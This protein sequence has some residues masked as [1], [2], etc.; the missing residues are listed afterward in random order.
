M[1]RL[2]SHRG[3]MDP[4]ALA[5]PHPKPKV[6]STFM[7]HLKPTFGRKPKLSEQS[8]F[9]EPTKKQNK[10]NI[11]GSETHMY[12]YHA[13]A[14]LYVCIYC[15]HTSA[16]M[17]HW[18]TTELLMH[19]N[20]RHCCHLQN[21]HWLWNQQHMYLYIY[22]AVFVCVCMRLFI[23]CTVTCCLNEFKFCHTLQHTHRD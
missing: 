11:F 20:H 7:A 22:N 13:Y 8:L 9:G 21:R 6:R 18:C 15:V 14:C 2:E 3:L 23:C 12:V 19:D 1:D 16:Y 5:R 17:L 4:K 10:D